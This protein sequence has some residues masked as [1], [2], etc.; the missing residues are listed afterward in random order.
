M[1]DSGKSGLEASE[2]VKLG[3]IR[4]S[5]RTSEAEGE[6]EGATCH[7]R[8]KV[9]RSRC[10]LPTVRGRRHHEARSFFIVSSSGCFVLHRH[11]QTWTRC[12]LD[13]QRWVTAD[14]NCDS[15]YWTRPREAGNTGCPEL[16]V[17][18]VSCRQSVSP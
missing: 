17:Q 18:V 13:G 14:G 16:S 6:T 7:L 15:P 11:F 2:P 5:I 3:V 9:I 4:G 10:A 12:D 1:D 8:G